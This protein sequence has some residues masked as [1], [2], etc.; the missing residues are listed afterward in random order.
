MRCDEMHRMLTNMMKVKN[1]IYTDNEVL[2]MIYYFQNKNVLRII[3]DWIHLRF[4]DTIKITD[5]NNNNN[6]YKEE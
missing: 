2:K 6:I 4:S 3:F 1:L 5:I